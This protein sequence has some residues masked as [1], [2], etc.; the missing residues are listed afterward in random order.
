[1]CSLHLA[2][3]LQES[4]QHQASEFFERSL[5]HWLEYPSRLFLLYLGVPYAPFIVH[6]FDPGD[7]Q[8]QVVDGS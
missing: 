2:A 4:H 5:L 7:E 8:H 3:A 6:C 1:M